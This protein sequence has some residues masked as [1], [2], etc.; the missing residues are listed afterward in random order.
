MSRAGS[1]SALF[2][3]PVPAS[4]AAG[5]ALEWSGVSQA[6]N[7]QG[8]FEAVGKWQNRWG[9]M[10]SNHWPARGPP[11]RAGQCRTDSRNPAGNRFGRGT[12][13]HSKYGMD[14]GPRWA[15]PDLA[16]ARRRCHEGILHTGQ[17]DTH[18]PSARRFLPLYQRPGRTE[19]RSAPI[20]PGNT[21]GPIQSPVLPRCA[22]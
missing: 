17:V 21:S 12:P 10:Q 5:P 15:N 3:C 9:A 20:I 19:R 13:G 18:Q 2:G 16:V 1:H 6:S 7:G 11:H 4:V 14:F 8:D 22:W